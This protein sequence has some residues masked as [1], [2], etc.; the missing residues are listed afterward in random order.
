[1]SNSRREYS[2]VVAKRVGGSRESE[3]I[4]VLPA[5]NNGYVYARTYAVS[6][7]ELRFN[8]YDLIEQEEQYLLN[9]GISLP[10]CIE[11]KD[12]NKYLPYDELE[13]AEE[14]QYIE[15]ITLLTN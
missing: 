7:K 9:R 12:P 2:V 15:V 5:F 14:Y 8:L 11:V 3:Y 10:N 6:W 13:S 4:A 1:M